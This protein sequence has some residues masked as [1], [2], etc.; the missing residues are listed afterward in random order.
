MKSLAGQTA[1]ATAQISDQVQQMQTA[2]RD[3]VRAIEGI[4]SRIDR[5]NHIATAIGAAVEEQGSAT[6]EIARNVQQ[7]AQGTHE[8]AA[9]I[10]KVTE[11][12][13]ATG[14]AAGQVLNAAKELSQQAEN[15]SGEVN[16]F[17]RSVKAA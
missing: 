10:G 17:V 9:N 7:A 11:G 3:A 16:R 8:V 1:K 15:L 12:A 13:N 14:T 6:Q 5:V 4:N 2:T